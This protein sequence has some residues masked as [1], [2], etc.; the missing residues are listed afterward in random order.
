MAKKA[1]VKGRR[2]TPSK[3][4]QMEI[5]LAGIRGDVDMYGPNDPTASRVHITVKSLEIL[6]HIKSSTWKKFLTEM[7]ADSRGNMRETDADMVR[8]ELVAVRPSLPSL[9]AE[10]RLRLKILPLRLHVDQDALDFLKRFFNFS[11]PAQTPAP[12][13]PTAVKK[14]APNEPFFRERSPLVTDI[15]LTN[16]RARRGL[17]DRIEARLQAEACGLCGASRRSNHRVDEFLP[18]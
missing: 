5:S 18:L 17:P 15:K 2:L 6:D 3:R 11:M 12:A 13:S 8:I 1:R 10:N 9:E 16:H 4:P 7:K 14:A